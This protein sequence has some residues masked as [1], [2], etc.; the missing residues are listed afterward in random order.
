MTD[1][2]MLN[3]YWYA[4]SHNISTHNPESIDTREVALFEFHFL[5]FGPSSHQYS[6]KLKIV[7]I[8]FSLNKSEVQVRHY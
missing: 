7:D 6:R 5:M 2:I 8:I 3:Q 1:S 4:R